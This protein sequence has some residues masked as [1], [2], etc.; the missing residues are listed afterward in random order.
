[1]LQQVRPVCLLNRS[2]GVAVEAG[3]A[4][5]NLATYKL[6]ILV[7]RQPN[8]NPCGGPSLSGAQWSDMTW[9]DPGSCIMAGSSVCS[10]VAGWF[11]IYGAV[12]GWLVDWAWFHLGIGDWLDCWQVWF[13]FCSCVCWSAAAQALGGHCGNSGRWRHCNIE[14][15]HVAVE[16][17]FLWLQDYSILNLKCTQEKYIE[18]AANQY[19]KMHNIWMFLHIVYYCIIFAIMIIFRRK[20]RNED[21][22]QLKKPTRETKRME[23][24]R[25]NKQIS[26][27]RRTTEI[28]SYKS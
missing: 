12:C 11:V 9:Y 1:M 19:V 24:T 2:R 18:R 6:Y 5:T 10:V 21:S 23:E 27:K 8:F 17:D 28:T 15:G 22:I 4:M 13:G 26:H 20:E 25:N 16:P 14:A 7:A 3:L